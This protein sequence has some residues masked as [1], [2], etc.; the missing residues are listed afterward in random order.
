[1]AKIKEKKMNNLVLSN[2]ATQF[3]NIKNTFVEW[4]NMLDSRKE[5][6]QKIPEDAKKK[7]RE[8]NKDPVLYNSWNFFL[9]LADFFG[10]DIQNK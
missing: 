10:V 6:Y 5:V 2:Q 3:N 7:W 9:E 1:M 4:R 8:N